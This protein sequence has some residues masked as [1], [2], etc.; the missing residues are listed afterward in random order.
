MFFK[1]VF[2]LNNGIFFNFFLIMT[3]FSFGQL[4]D[5]DYTK[6]A[7]EESSLKFQLVRAATIG[8][9][10]LKHFDVT[11]EAAKITY[12]SRGGSHIVFT[13][14][15]TQTIWNGNRKY[16]LNTFDYLMNP[17]GGD[18]NGNFFFSYPVSKQDMA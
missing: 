11:L 13:L 1:R 4:L 7:R 3:N 10:S 2:F 16:L 12:D 6:D 14:Y 15:G 5:I 18:I 9:S 17:I 8:F